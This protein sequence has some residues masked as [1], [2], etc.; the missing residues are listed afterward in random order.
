M[1][2][3]TQDREPLRRGNG[4]VGILYRLSDIWDAFEAGAREAREAIGREA[5]DRP[6]GYA[7]PG[8]DWNGVIGAGAVFT[9]KSTAIG[10]KAPESTDEE[11]TGLFRKLIKDVAN[12]AVLHAGWPNGADEPDRAVI[13]RRGE[14]A[15]YLAGYAVEIEPPESLR[16]LLALLRAPR[17]EG[18][19]DALG[20]LQ[21][22]VDEYL[23]E[24][25]NN[26]QFDAEAAFAALSREIRAALRSEAPGEDCHETD[27]IVDI[28]PANWQD[29]RVVSD[30]A[31]R[32]THVPT[33]ITV[34]CDDQPTLAR[35]KAVAIAGLRAAVRA[36]RRGEGGG[37]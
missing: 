1:S 35:N 21:A 15:E 8:Y 24:A 22:S 13:D 36:A 3:T 18:E 7:S 23:W 2:E 26:P 33:G 27:V 16:K 20:M 30:A 37:E 34:I 9:P 25:Q 5:C 32:I 19:G 28:H 31:V 4:G 6:K 14:I 12:A 10:Q 17:G 11:I 29:G